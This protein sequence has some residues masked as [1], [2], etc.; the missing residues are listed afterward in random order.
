MD[1]VRA[2]WR[3]LKGSRSRDAGPEPAGRPRCAKWLKSQ[4]LFIVR[5][6]GRELR[7]LVI[8][9]EWRTA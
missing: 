9:L 6:N 2:R 8:D 7:G 4:S 3:T 1:W 5:W